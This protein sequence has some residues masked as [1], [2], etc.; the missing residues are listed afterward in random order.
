MA[1]AKRRFVVK[2]RL[3]LSFFGPDWA[4]CYIDFTPITY[5]EANKLSALRDVDAKKLNDTEREKLANDTITMLKD[6][7]VAG[8]GFAGDEGVVDLEADDLTELPVEI[9]TKAIVVLRGELDP[10]LPAASVS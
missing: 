1:K 6:H 4:E 2:K 5:T 8:R 9:M 10:K 3:D 7:F